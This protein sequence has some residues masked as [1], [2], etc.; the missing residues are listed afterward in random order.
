MTTWEVSIS[1]GSR[2]ALGFTETQVSTQV[3]YPLG[4]DSDG[5]S[6]GQ[7]FE[8]DQGNV[9]FSV[10]SLSLSLDIYDSSISG[11]I[12]P[13]AGK[14]PMKVWQR[15]LLRESEELSVNSFFDFSPDMP[16]L[17]WQMCFLIYI[18]RSWDKIISKSL[19]LSLSLFFFLTMPLGLQDL[20]SLTRDWTLGP[21]QQKH[22]VLTTGPPGNSPL[23]L[24]NVPKFQ[25]KNT[26][27]SACVCHSVMS[28]SLQPHRLKSTRL[29]CPWNSPG[30]NTRVGCHFLL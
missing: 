7:N 17:P 3:C 22:Q 29:L 27:Q 11:S 20:S 5:T 6:L 26:K 16:C 10:L 23:S 18:R 9:L 25:T 4:W 21:W 19:S 28:Y 8:T 12:T 2:R 1:L 13:K 14:D 30:K 15:E 24:F